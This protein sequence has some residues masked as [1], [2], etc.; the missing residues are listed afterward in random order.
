MGEFWQSLPLPEVLNRLETTPLGLSYA[1]ADAVRSGAGPNLL[2]DARRCTLLIALSQLNSPRIH[3]LL[4]AAVVSAFTGELSDAAFVCVVL[5]VNTAIGTWQ[6]GQAESSARALRATAARSG[7]R[8]GGL[9]GRRR[10]G[11]D[12]HGRPRDD[13]ARHRAPCR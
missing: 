10:G 13:G 7:G 8:C 12:D 11:Q 9:P 2:P 5:V 3:L 1:A 4:I 6:E